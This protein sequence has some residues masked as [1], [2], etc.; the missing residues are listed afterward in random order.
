LEAAAGG[1]KDIASVEFFEQKKH[2]LV[3]IGEYQQELDGRIG[4]EFCNYALSLMEV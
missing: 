3:K 1:Y 2:Y 4:D